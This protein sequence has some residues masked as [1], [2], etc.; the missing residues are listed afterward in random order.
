ME[1][2]EEFQRQKLKRGIKGVLKEVGEK[3]DEKCK[4]Y[5]KVEERKYGRE[6]SDL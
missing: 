1:K 5:I 3:K 6:K 4:A 2:K